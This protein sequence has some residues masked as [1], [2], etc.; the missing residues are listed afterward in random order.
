MAVDKQITFDLIVNG[1]RKQGKKSM[2]GHLCK[3]RSEDGYRCAV[4]QLIEDNEY[5]PGFDDKAKQSEKDNAFNFVKNKGHDDGLLT[6]LMCCHD[7]KEVKDWENNF[8][9]IAERY[10]LIYT[11]RN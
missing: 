3:F 6:S 10:G 11:P 5:R 1:L 7:H 9:K 8:A 4:G 2:D